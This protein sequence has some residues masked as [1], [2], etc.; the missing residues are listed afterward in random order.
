MKAK[1]FIAMSIA[2]ILT[3]CASVG[4]EVYENKA[5]QSA[6][7]DADAETVFYRLTAEKPEPGT[8]CDGLVIG[9]AMYYPKR[10][11]F[12]VI[13]TTGVDSRPVMTATGKAENGKTRLTVGSQSSLIASRIEP[14]MRFASGSRCK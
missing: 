14:V 9:S 11:Q 1:N 7:I 12:R 13:W 6:L 10:E 8:V 4:S 5:Q 3:G 2:A